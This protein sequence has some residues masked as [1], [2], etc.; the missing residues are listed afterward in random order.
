MQNWLFPTIDNLDDC[1]IDELKDKFM[2]EVNEFMEALDE[3]DCG[4]NKLAVISE[5]LDVAHARESIFKKLNITYS[6]LTEGIQ[7]VTL[8]N[9]LRGYYPPDNRTAAEKNN[10]Q[11]GRL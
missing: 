4:R 11:S 3:Y 8:K 10:V 1:S 6:D 2:E 9:K 5:G 7:F